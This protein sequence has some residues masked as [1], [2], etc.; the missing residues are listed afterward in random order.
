MLPAQVGKALSYRLAHREADGHN[1]LRGTEDVINNRGVRDP[2]LLY[3]L[4]QAYAVLGDKSSALR[5][6]Q[7][8]IEDG[9][10][11]YSY[12]AS[13]ALLDNIRRDARFEPLLQQAH[14]RQNQ[15]ERRFF[16]QR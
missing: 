13:D 11:P 8:A 5:L 6:L 10:F 14:I 1:L 2:E 3:K 9:F 15:F 12:F 16:N 7:R 4:A